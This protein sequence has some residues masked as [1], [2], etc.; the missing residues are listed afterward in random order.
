MII[1]FKSCP[2]SGLTLFINAV[3]FT[4]G[5]YHTVYSTKLSNWLQ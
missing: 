2:R 3:R 5:T 4:P 1:I